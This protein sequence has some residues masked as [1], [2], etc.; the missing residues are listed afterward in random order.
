MITDTATLYHVRWMIR[1]DMPE[2]LEI[3]HRLK[4]RWNEDQIIHCLQQCNCIGMVAEAGE[5]V[6]GF[7]VYELHKERLLILCGGINRKWRGRG[8]GTAI[9]KK[10]VSKL[11]PHRR[12]KLDVYVNE[13]GLDDVCKFLSRCGFRGIRYEGDEILMRYNVP[14]PSETT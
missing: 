1:R 12:T 9:V 4:P 10:M 5:D 2:V 3:S 8:A 14:T 11:S 7:I 13:S 6:V